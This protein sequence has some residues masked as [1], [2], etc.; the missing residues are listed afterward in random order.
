MSSH[1]LHGCGCTRQ[2]VLSA[3]SVDR[4]NRWSS[5]RWRMV[6]S[7]KEPRIK[8]TLSPG[9][10]FTKPEFKTLPP[11]TPCTTSG[12]RN[13]FKNYL[14][15]CLYACRSERVCMCVLGVGTNNWWSDFGRKR[16][17]C[18]SCLSSYVHMTAD[19]SIPWASF[20]VSWPT[21][22]H[23]MLGVPHCSRDRAALT[24]QG[25]GWKVTLKGE[26]RE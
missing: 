22:L 15:T 13:K 1:R 12:Q 19:F 11:I 16:Q 21:L 23:G 14:F 24:E 20:P 9:S 17:E 18:W 4:W 7:A 3:S 5:G 2:H 6:H 25:S 26:V 10:V 8:A